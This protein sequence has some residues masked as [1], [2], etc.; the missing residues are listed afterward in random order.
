[1][2]G[3]VMAGEPESLH[4]HEPLK[5]RVERHNY[6]R[7]LML[8]DGVFAIAIT[9]LALE[10]K[11]PAQWDGSVEG[12]FGATGRP[13]VG[14]LFGFALVG[15]FWFVHR[16]LF[17]ELEQVDGV[18]TLLNLVLLGLVGLTPFVVRMI[19]EAGPTRGLPFYL[20]AVGAVFGAI[21]LIHAWVMFRPRLFHAGVDRV[22]FRITAFFQAAMAVALMA[23]GSW[24]LSRHR[25]V[26]GTLF[27][28][29]VIILAVAQRAIRRRR[30]LQMSS[31]SRP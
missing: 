5:A 23:L 8:S 11:V 1:M 14:Y 17:A 13:L 22:G 2:E 18:I 7:L 9:L 28:A 16:R 10:L 30:R 12:L 4:I 6:D 29:V 3:A 19:A 26:D 21:A 20:I 25:P 31:T 27:S 24:A 15:V